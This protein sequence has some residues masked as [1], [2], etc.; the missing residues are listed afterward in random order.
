MA[1]PSTGSLIAGFIPTAAACGFAVLTVYLLGGQW[2]RPLVL[3]T[4]PA[5]LF[6]LMILQALSLHARKRALG[7]FGT[8]SAVATLIDGAN[9]AVR[10]LKIQ[11]FIAGYAEDRH[12]VFVTSGHESFEYPRGIR[13]DLVS[14]SNGIQVFIHLVFHKRVSNTS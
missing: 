1:Q 10:L 13:I 14:N 8:A 5:A 11:L 9:P 2:S 12:V 6:G 7:R 3:W 4:V